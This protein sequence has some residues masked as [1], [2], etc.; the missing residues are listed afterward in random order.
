[1]PWWGKS[2]APKDEKPAVAPADS[3]SFDPDKLPPR[4]KLP[5]KL[6]KIVDKADAENSNFF[7]DIKEG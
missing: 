5:R 4:E 6:Q 1:M 2:E 3:A 7:D